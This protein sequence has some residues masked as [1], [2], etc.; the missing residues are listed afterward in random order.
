[1]AGDTLGSLEFIIKSMKFLPQNNDRRSPLHSRVI[2]SVNCLHTRH[3]GNAML[4][5]EGKKF[6][7]TFL[8]A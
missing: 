1:M 4:G 5:L 3:L 6:F 2:T 8:T 7:F